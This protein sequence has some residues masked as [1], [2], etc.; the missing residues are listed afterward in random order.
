M[1]KKKT[2]VLLMR[3]S[4]FTQIEFFAAAGFALK[5][6][7]RFEAR[8]FTT[9]FVFTSDRIFYVTSLTKGFCERKFEFHPKDSFVFV[10]KGRAVKK[11][12]N[13]INRRRICEAS[14]LKPLWFP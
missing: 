1:N 10:H 4:F 7:D 3:K 8:S 2:K 9:L 5:C 6:H 13:A 12:L 14:P 11:Q